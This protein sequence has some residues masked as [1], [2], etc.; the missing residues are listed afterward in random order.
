M[1]VKSKASKRKLTNTDK[2]N[3]IDARIDKLCGAVEDI[4]A[5]I[6]NNIGQQAV[7]AVEEKVVEHLE[8]EQN[9][10]TKNTE[11]V[12]DAIRN[13]EVA[14]ITKLGENGVPNIHIDT[15]RRGYTTRTNVTGL[16]LDM[17]EKARQQR[18]QKHKF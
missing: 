9:T 10:I 16:V 6:D 2:I 1:A 8:Q 4:K 17:L 5:S 3:L 12:I 18:K 7:A 11:P 15:D 14:V 13:A